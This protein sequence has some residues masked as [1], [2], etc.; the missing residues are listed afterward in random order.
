MDSTVSFE[1]KL[2]KTWPALPYLSLGV[3]LS[4]VYLASSGTTWISSD[5]VNGGSLLPFAIAVSLAIGVTFVVAAL[6]HRQIQALLDRPA[7]ILASSSAAS[8]GSILIVLTGPH[9]R[10]HA[11]PIDSAATIFVVGSVLYGVGLAVIMLRCGKLYSIL[12]P[13]KIIRYVAYSLLFLSTVFLVVTGAPSWTPVQEGPSFVG[14]V[15]FAVAPIFAGLFSMLPRNDEASSEKETETPAETTNNHSLPPLPKTFWKLIAIIFVFSSIV[16]SICAYTVL[17]STVESTL[18]GMRLIMLACLMLALALLIVSVALGDRHF[19]FGKIYSMIMVIAV[20]IV[21]CLPF[22]SMFHETLSQIM[23]FASSAFELFLW[24]TLSLIAY[25]RRASAVL[26]FGCGYGAY[27]LSIAFGRI[28]GAQS[29]GA[30]FET[31]GSSFGYMFMA[32]AML[33]CAF[34]IFSEREFYRLFESVE[35]K[36]KTLDELLAEESS[37]NDGSTN[38]TESDLAAKKSRFS[39]VIENLSDLHRLSPRETEVLRYL[40]MGYNS[41]AVANKLNISWNTVRTHIRNVYGKL[42]VHSQQDLIALVDKTVKE[43]DGDKL[44]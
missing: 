33:F 9:Y 2:T 28:F 21:S 37:D 35:L 29:L 43:D 36:A 6:F 44:S 32:L 3:A 18:E 30:L 5:E 34:V 17:S 8:L 23:A 39:S 11:L 20:A 40:A 12:P 41:S 1:T 16:S 26:V 42:D 14:I 10:Y 25:Q 15:L 4:S 7:T 27:Q 38:K 22:I 19:D 31:V 24:C 13:W